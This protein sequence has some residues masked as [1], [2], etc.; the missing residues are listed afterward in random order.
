MT[1]AICNGH[2]KITQFLA[3]WVTSPRF[4]NLVGHNKM[5][6]KRSFMYSS[7]CATSVHVHL[8]PI[9]RV[10]FCSQL[11]DCFAIECHANMMFDT[12]FVTGVPAKYTPLQRF[13]IIYI[14]PCPWGVY[15]LSSWLWICT[16][17]GQFHWDP[18]TCM[19]VFGVWKETRT[20]P[21]FSMQQY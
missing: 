5:R 20:G 11:P 8:I 13:F 2:K 19:Y 10:Y 16:H 9:T 17:Y 18:W 4:W 15:N 1:V 14:I 7:I 3:Y 21:L 6:V 12:V